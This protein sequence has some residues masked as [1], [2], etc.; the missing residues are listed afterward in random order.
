M[1]VKY[2]KSSVNG[3]RTLKLGFL[4]LAS[5][6]LTACGGANFQSPVELW[7]KTT[8]KRDPQVV[9]SQRRQ[10]LL[11]RDVAISL[12]QPS[13]D[14]HSAAPS[15]INQRSAAGQA[16]PSNIVPPRPEPAGIPDLGVSPQSN[17]RPSTPPQL[18]E[19]SLLGRVGSWFGRQFDEASEVTTVAAPAEFASATEATGASVITVASL[20]APSIVS[21]VPHNVPSKSQR[22][23]IQNN[24]VLAATSP[25][26][27]IA[28]R[29]D[30]ALA[31][32]AEPLSRAVEPRS[33]STETLLAQIA[34][35]VPT[36]PIAPTQTAANGLAALPPKQFGLDRGDV[37][38]PAPVPLPS[39]HI[40]S[41][42]PS[43]GTRKDA[44]QPIVE[45]VSDEEFEAII[46]RQQV[47][48]EEVLPIGGPLIEIDEPATP[49]TPGEQLL[50]QASEPPTLRS[51]PEAP[52]RLNE[53]RDNHPAIQQRLGDDKLDSDAK[54]VE[55]H[56]QIQEEY[57]DSLRKQYL[58]QQGQD[59]Q[60]SNQRRTT[61]STFTRLGLLPLPELQFAGEGLR[62][63]DNPVDIRFV[64][65]SAVTS[66]EAVGKK[67][68]LLSF[69]PDFIYKPALKE[70]REVV[71]DVQLPKTP[72][73]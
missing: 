38:L 19:P 62:R 73:A 60:R 67:V 30:I 61:E 66:N 40:A 9:S 29:E 26:P 3:S 4:I 42:T 17:V 52:I 11:N 25:E 20:E 14:Q 21:S 10:P 7:K 48:G 33:G 72:V 56:R 53:V 36:T 57:D 2:L 69:V 71:Y 16:A 47:A 44:I 51:I 13:A 45:E 27:V 22:K 64:R 23:P 32:Q 70:E 59:S 8:A 37:P 68:G 65:P 31:N 18:S 43:F 1:A 12:S 6:S 58:E 24:V 15:N 55:L 34:D 35:D 5:S 50:A 54:K 28:R 46:A 63:V 49:F 41:S 39:K